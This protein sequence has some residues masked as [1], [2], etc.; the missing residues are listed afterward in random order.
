[1]IFWRTIL[2]EQEEPEKESFKDSL[3]EIFYIVKACLSSF[4]FWVPP[5]FAVYMFLELYL[6]CVSPLLVLIGPIITIVYVLFWEE[7]RVK[8]QYGIKDV[9]VLSSSD[10]LFSGPRKAASVEVE[11]LVEEYEK[12]IKR[13]K[14]PKNAVENDEQ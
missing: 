13:P 9:K 5:L 11:E 10:P 2:E 6:L 8:A 1:V 4:W 14:K 12:L 3:L 7:K